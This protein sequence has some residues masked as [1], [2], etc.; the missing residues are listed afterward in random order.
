MQGTGVRAPHHLKPMGGMAQRK[1]G[2]GGGS[3]SGS[4]NSK[5]QRSANAPWDEFGRPKALGFGKP[6][7]PI[8][9]TTKAL[10]GK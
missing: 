5:L 8:G 7:G 1:L 9:K 2:G 4:N 6:L 3:I 10:Q